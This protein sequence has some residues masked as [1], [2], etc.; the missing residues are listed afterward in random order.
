M[1]VWIVRPRPIRAPG[2]TPLP[3]AH[4]CISYP[5]ERYFVFVSKRAGMNYLTKI[6][7]GIPW[8]ELEKEFIVE[9]KE[10]VL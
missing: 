4:I 9:R 1:R 7:P 8:K 3:A 6:N 10:L 2:T 5:D